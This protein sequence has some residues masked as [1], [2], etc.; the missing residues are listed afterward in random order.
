[1]KL[2]KKSQN[3]LFVE[4]E[5]YNWAAPKSSINRKLIL[6]S[7]VFIIVGLLFSTLR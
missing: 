6:L 7:V 3:C 5:R 2:F 4:E 1:M